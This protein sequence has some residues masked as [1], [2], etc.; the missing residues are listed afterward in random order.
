LHDRKPKGST[1]KN[2]VRPKEG[3]LERGEPSEKRKS[4]KISLSQKPVRNWIATCSEREETAGLQ[5]EP[6]TTPIILDGNLTGGKRIRKSLNTREEKEQRFL[7][8]GKRGE[9]LLQK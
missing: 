4:T 8:R 9:P 7:R 1:V 5:S 2:S 3:P 6:F